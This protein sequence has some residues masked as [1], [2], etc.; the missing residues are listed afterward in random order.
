M[1]FKK[2]VDFIFKKL[3]AELPAKLSYHTIDHVRDVYGAAE[4]IGK[5]EGVSEADMQLLLTAAAYHD[6]GFIKG[7]AGHEEES[8]RLATGTLP[9]FGYK[10]GDIEKICGMIRATKKPQSPKSHLEEILADADLD[11][12][13]RDDFFTIGDKLYRELLA[14]GIVN[15]EEEWHQVQVRF[16]ENHHYFTKTSVN[17]REAKKEQHLKQVKAKLNL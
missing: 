11:Y 9:Y 8:C 5:Q 6:A 7:A 3:L 15:N 17:L 2:A 14:S 4:L 12:L 16:F 10:P 13:G 1:Q